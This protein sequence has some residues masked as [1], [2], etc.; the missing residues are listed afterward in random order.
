MSVYAA[1]DGRA[2][3]DAQFSAAYYNKQDGNYYVYIGANTEF[4]CEAPNY[5]EVYANTDGQSGMQIS[6]K[7]TGGWPQ[8][9]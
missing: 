8:T 3:T 1:N 2:I 5:Q 9:Y 6:L 7:Y 4:W